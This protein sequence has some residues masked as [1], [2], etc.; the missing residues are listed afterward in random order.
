[1]ET[2]FWRKCSQC[3]KTIALGGTYYECSVS[4]CTGQRT[5][6]VFCSVPCWEVHV[7]GARHRDAYAV[8]NTAP[9]TPWV[10]P[11]SASA[12]PNKSE[13]ALRQI[14]MPSANGGGQRRIIPGAQTKTAS[15]KQVPEDVLIV[16]S[17]LKDY[18]RAQS[19]MNTADE[20]KD[21]LSDFVRR[22]CDQA[23]E[24]ARADGRKTVM[25]R[26]FQ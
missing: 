5:G 25:K 12:P 20:V 2:E 17:K 19:E 10:P 16:V 8:E 24:R 4:T 13:G 23:I 3:K 6:Y 1:M 7:P 18:I 21:I 15:I 22:I 9:R 14:S 11:G 26:D